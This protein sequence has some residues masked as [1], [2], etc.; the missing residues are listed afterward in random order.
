MFAESSCCLAQ[1]RMLLL[2][3]CLGGGALCLYDCKPVDC[4]QPIVA[5]LG[6][7]YTLAQ[8]FAREVWQMQSSGVI[9]CIKSTVKHVQRWQRQT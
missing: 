1:Y 7:E 4:R 2:P 3:M 5:W 9:N 6:K 8:I